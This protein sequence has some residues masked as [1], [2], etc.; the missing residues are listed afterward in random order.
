MNGETIFGTVDDPRIRRC[1]LEIGGD[2][3]V[4]ARPFIEAAGSL[5]GVYSLSTTRKGSSGTSSTVQRSRF[6][7]GTLGIANVLL[8]GPAEVHVVLEVL[9]EAG[10]RL[11]GLDRLIE[12]PGPTT[13]I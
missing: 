9:D 11:C 6:S 12:L 10:K 1:G 5:G 4:S 8:P 3:V 7:G 13:D 2:D